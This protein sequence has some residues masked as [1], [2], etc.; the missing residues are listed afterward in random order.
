VAP[1][2]LKKDES[3]NITGIDAKTLAVIRLYLD[4]A[5]FLCRLAPKRW[6]PL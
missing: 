2:A 6:D 1:P 3:G 5:T 4:P